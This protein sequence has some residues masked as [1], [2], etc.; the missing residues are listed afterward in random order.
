MAKKESETNKLIKSRNIEDPLDYIF[1][2]RVSLLFAKLFYKMGMSAN[3][4]T[5]CSLITGVIGAAFLAFPSH[6]H[7]VFFVW[8]LVVGIFLVILSAVFDCADGQVARM[9][10]HGSLYGRCF[11]GFADGMVYFAIYVAI[12][13]RIMLFDNIPFTTIPWSGWIW[14][15]AVPVGVYFHAYQA[16]TADYHKNMYM[17]LTGSKHCE[18]STV[19]DLKKQFDAMP[20]RTFFQ[21]LVCNSYLSYT[22]SQEHMTPRFQELHKKIIENGGVIPEKVTEMWKKGTN[23]TVWLTNILVF[24]FRTYVLFILMA[25]NLT[26]WIFPINVIVLE[27]LRIFLLVKY[28]RLAKKCVKEGFD[29]I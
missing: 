24:N 11:D 28:E 1:T 13:I 20:D 18:L 15:I 14:I 23:S 19:E 16:R 17:Y 27:A 4:V 6:Q 10:G 3:N 2:E 29:E 22:K 5:I 9:S 8:P 25:F 26:F 7:G 21:K 12:S